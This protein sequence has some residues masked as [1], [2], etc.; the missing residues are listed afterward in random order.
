[1][2]G[3]GWGIITLGIIIG[4]GIVL[5]ATMGANV[6]NCPAGYAYNTNGTTMF[7]DNRC[8]LVGTSGTQ[9]ANAGN[10]TAPSLGTQ[11]VNSIYGY[12]GTGSGGLASWMP[13]IIV[14]TIGLFLIGA[15]MVNRG[16]RS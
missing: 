11:T 14:L 16:K 10:S 4:V 5:L 12:L 2:T 1:M 15:F 8:C 13:L 7:A 6:A 9:C 3:L